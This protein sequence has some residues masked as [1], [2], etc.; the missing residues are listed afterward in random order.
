MIKNMELVHFTG[1]MEENITVHGKMEN[2]MDVDNI[3]SSLVKNVLDNGSMENELSGLI[4]VFQ[5]KLDDYPMFHY[6]IYNVHLY[7]SI[8]LW[9]IFKIIKIKSG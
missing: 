2:S 7:Q 4:K 5:N 9:N 1:L 6:F 3:T 8:E